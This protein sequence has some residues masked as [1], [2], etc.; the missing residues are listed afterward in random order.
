VVAIVWQSVAMLGNGV[1]PLH[2]AYTILRLAAGFGLGAAAGVALGVAMGRYRWA[3]DLLLPLVS[4][5]NPIPGL[6]YAP[7]FVI[8]FGL[9][10]LPAVLLGAFATA[11]PVAV[12]T[13]TGV[14][15]VKEIW[16]RSARDP[17]CLRGRLSRRSRHRPLSA[18][19]HGRSRGA[20]RSAAAAGPA[21]HP[22]SRVPEGGRAP[23]QQPLKRRPFPLP[24]GTALG[25]GACYPGARFASGRAS[26][27]HL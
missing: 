4:V 1:L 6:A 10:D 19:R 21:E 9:G 25:P 8:W 18:P 7:L 3:E 5:G 16:V 13:W 26:R 12:N 20:D 11:F 24:A 15:A 22:L 23:P 14:R 27:R 2:A 17:Q